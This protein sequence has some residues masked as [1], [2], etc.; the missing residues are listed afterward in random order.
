MESR[1]E[2]SVEANTTGRVIEALKAHR[3]YLKNGTS[4]RADG[5]ILSDIMEGMSRKELIEE[6]LSTH[7]LGWLV[8]NGFIKKT[9][10]AIQV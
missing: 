4:L 9:E 5:Y 8:E 1:Y 7:S 10:H 2:A 6:I 3:D